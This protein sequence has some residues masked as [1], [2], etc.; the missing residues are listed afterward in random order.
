MNYSESATSQDKPQM[1]QGC[2]AYTNDTRNHLVRCSGI[3]AKI[4][5]LCTGLGSH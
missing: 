1:C 4:K 2:A 3:E 5:E